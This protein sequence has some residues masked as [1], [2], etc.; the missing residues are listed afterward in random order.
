MVLKVVFPLL[1]CWPLRFPQEQKTTASFVIVGDCVHILPSFKKIYHFSYLK[2]IIQCLLMYSQCCTITIISSMFFI[3]KG[4]FITTK[5]QFLFSPYSQSW[6]SL[7]LLFL[8]ILIFISLVD[9]DNEH[10]KMHL[11][12]ICISYFLTWILCPFLNWIIYL[13]AAEFLEFFIYILDVNLVEWRVH[14]HFLL[15]LSIV[16]WFYLLFPL[17][18]RNFWMWYN[19]IFLFGFCCL[20]CWT[21]IQKLL[22]MS[23]S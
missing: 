18:C 6:Q 13:I 3:S 12:A 15:I 21:L 17:L 11:L 19:A 14:K 8:Q 20:C 23:M 2:S 1:M 5:Q 7:I 10:V 22:H 4:T 16:S 9:N